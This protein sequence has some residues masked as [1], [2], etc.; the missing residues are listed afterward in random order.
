MPST[1]T[2]QQ[3][4]VPSTFA[5]ALGCGL[6][7]GLL[8]AFSAFVMTAL[9]RVPP[10]EGIRAMQTINVAIVTPVFLVVF[11]GTLAASIVAAIG[12]S[13]PHVSPEVSRLL[14]AGSACYVIGV[15]GVTAVF[16]IP[17]N[18]TLAGM[19]PDS[20]EAALYWLQYLS[21]WTAWNHVRTA[22]AIAGTA[23]FVLALRLLGPMSM[24]A[25]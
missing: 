22:A 5:A 4:L 6:M 9:G 23:A 18:N 12:A 15:I 13:S 11:L 24:T 3:V 7:A 10:A 19:N 21:S 20:A 16:N 17:R 8:F 1:S 2:L 25:G 14:L